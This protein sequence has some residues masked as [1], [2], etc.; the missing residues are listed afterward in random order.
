M[1]KS[2]KGIIHYLLVESRGFK[3]QDIVIVSSTE[4][5]YSAVLLKQ[6]NLGQGYVELEFQRMQQVEI[7]EVV[8][9]TGY[10]FL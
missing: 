2:S 9:A 6:K 8:P 7:T 3:S 5:T 4:K 1:K 10:D